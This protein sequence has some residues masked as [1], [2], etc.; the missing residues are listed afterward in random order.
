[1]DRCSEKYSRAFFRLYWVFGESMSP[2][3]SGYAHLILLH[4]WSQ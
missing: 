2:R 3:T 4:G 1:V